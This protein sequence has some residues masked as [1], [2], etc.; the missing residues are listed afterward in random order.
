[1]GA[2]SRVGTAYPYGPHEFTH[3]FSVAQYLIF[4]TIVSGPLFVF[5]FILFWPLYSHIR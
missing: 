5:I 2:S 1:M 4:C 3:V